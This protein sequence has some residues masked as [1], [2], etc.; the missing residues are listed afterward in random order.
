MFKVG[1][2]YELNTN[3]HEFMSDLRTGDRLRCVSDSPDGWGHY[4]FEV[5][6]CAIEPESVG[7]TQYACAKDIPRLVPAVEQVKA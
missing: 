4:R 3:E 6:R 5:V 7:W 1:Q 2:V